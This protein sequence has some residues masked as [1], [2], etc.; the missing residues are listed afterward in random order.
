MNYDRVVAAPYGNMT[1]LRH[2]VL[3]IAEG[4]RFFA[5]TVIIAG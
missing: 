2:P 5:L 3:R 4:K 1:N